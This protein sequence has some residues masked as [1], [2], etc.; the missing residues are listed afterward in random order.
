M[1]KT[2][3]LFI[4][5]DMYYF[6]H[7]R[8]PN[9]DVYGVFH[10]PTG[11]DSYLL[12]VLR[13]L[14]RKETKYF[15]LDWYKNLEKYERVVVMDTA[16]NLDFR[17]LENI[18]LKHPICEKYLYSWNVVK[19]EKQY[20]RQ[21]SAA[22]AAGFKFYSHNHGDC[23]KRGLIFNTIMY[24][25]NLLLP[26][27]KPICDT[28]FLGYLKDRKEKMAALYQV[29]T[30]VGLTPRF[31]IVGTEDTEALPFEF[32]KSRIGYYE[33]LEMLSKSRAI[34]DISQEGQD[35]Y[36]LRVMEAIFFNKKL[37]TTNAAVRD[38]DFY[39]PDKILVVNFNNI[40]AGELLCFFEKEY[41]PYTDAV[42]EYYSFEAWIDR[43]GR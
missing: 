26:E 17:L 36:S 2:L 38:A 12:K 11:E 18:N 15:Y 30:D 41:K 7:I 33:Y 3:M 6:N 37:I 43:F 28:F 39:D 31:V 8:H 25:K 21:R 19:N 24:D 1:K 29:I 14:N 34:L 40:N 5:P 22:D 9:I 10:T 32:S 4:T 20:R 23:E 27:S 16:L 35:G 42:R 13:R